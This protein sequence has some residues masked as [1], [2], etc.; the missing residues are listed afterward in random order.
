M[1]KN[2]STEAPVH[3]PV[4]LLLTLLLAGGALAGCLGQEDA[5]NMPLPS[6]A[7]A[8][9]PAIVT[10]DGRDLRFQLQ[11][12]DEVKAPTWSV[13]DHFGVHVFFGLADEDGEHF[14]TVVVEADN[15]GY[16]LAAADQQIAKIHSLIDL[17][18]LGSVR[19]DNLATTGLGGDWALYDFP[20]YD[21][22][23]WTGDFW[24]TYDEFNGEAVPVTFQTTYAPEIPGF[25][26][27]LPGY[28]ITATMEDG[29]VLAA[30]DYVPAIGWFNEFI[31]YELDS[32]DGDYV[33]RATSMGAGPDWTGTC[34]V[35]ES[36]EAL[37]VFSDV[38]L[39]PSGPMAE[40]NPHGSFDVAEE[41][42]YVFGI[43]YAYAFSGVS[44]AILMDPEGNMYDER[45]VAPASG[46]GSG[47]FFDLP[48]VPGT[49]RFFAGS[50]GVASGAG[51][52]FYTI[53]ENAF[54]LE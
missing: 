18:I 30:Y 44:N 49:W 33:F 35:D 47:S 39:D 19:A 17:P 54:R 53:Q 16:L 41:A 15:D 3:P 7:N 37:V 42:D 51:A 26:G 13:A 22:K 21:G 1:R 50:A 11:P 36:A 29:F 52:Q 46:S 25:A 48:S 34:Y 24:V 14:D 27:T 9:Q 2:K 6:A 31:E 12:R 32:E 38:I 45:V 43:M 23:T 5:S 20:L 28:K 40:P 10:D 8:A 4:A